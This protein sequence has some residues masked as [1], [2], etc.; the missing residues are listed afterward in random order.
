M[1]RTSAQSLKYFGGMICLH[2]PHPC[3]VRNSKDFLL[4]IE[5][6]VVCDTSV[7]LPLSTWINILYQDKAL[8]IS[9]HQTIKEYKRQAE[10]SQSLL[11]FILG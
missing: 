8:R 3:F 11:M 10:T 5:G 7:Y 9:R 4:N 1:K 6:R 2:I